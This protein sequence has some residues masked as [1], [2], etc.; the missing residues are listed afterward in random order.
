MPPLARRVPG[1]LRHADERSGGERSDGVDEAFPPPAEPAKQLA[2][3][4]GHFDVGVVTLL[5][6]VAEQ[7]QQAMHHENLP[8]GGAIGWA[9]DDRQCT[10]KGAK[11]ECVPDRRPRRRAEGG[12]RR[13]EGGGRRAQRLTRSSSRSV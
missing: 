13:A 7:V 2:L 10:G 6:V 4:G 3:S 12:G 8:G 11:Q 9:W 1:H 5:V